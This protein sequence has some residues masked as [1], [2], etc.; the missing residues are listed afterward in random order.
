[1]ISQVSNISNKDH[2]N[3][4][5]EKTRGHLKTSALFFPWPITGAIC[6]GLQLFSYDQASLLIIAGG[7]QYSKHKKMQTKKKTSYS[8]SCDILKAGPKIYNSQMTFRLLNRTTAIIIVSLSSSFFVFTLKHHFGL[9]TSYM[10]QSVSASVSSSYSRIRSYFLWPDNYCG[11][12]FFSSV[13]LRLADRCNPRRNFKCA[14]VRWKI[15]IKPLRDGC[16]VWTFFN[17]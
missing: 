5:R 4:K 3:N 13:F 12:F 15:W 10:V 17:L 9:I 2:V 7:D 8:I 1:M 16:G 11:R 6:N 14:D